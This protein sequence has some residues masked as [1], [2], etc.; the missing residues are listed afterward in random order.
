MAR[1]T[2]RD[3]L[4]NGRAHGRYYMYHQYRCSKGIY[5]FLNLKR[6]ED[7]SEESAHTT[8]ID[9]ELY[10][11]DGEESDFGMDDPFLGEHLDDPR[12]PRRFKPKK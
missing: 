9:Y 4:L 6:N 1:R 11:S 2:L 12:A 8:L 5:Q 10:S 7:T 3:D